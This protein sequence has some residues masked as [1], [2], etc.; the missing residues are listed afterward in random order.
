MVGGKSKGRLYG[1][2]QIG[3]TYSSGSESLKH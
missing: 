1:I 2:E 3:A